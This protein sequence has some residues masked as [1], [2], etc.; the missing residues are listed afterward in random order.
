MR[1]VR[2]LPRWTLL[3]TVGPHTTFHIGGI[4]GNEAFLL[5]AE[6]IADVEVRGKGTDDGFVILGVHVGAVSKAGRLGGKYRGR[7]ARTWR[8]GL[9]VSGAGRTGPIGIKQDVVNQWERWTM[10]PV[11]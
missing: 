9:L 3:Y 8:T 6:R 10:C 4:E 1:K 2:T 5:P 11:L 7:P